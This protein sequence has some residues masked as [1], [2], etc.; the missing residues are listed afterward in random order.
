MDPNKHSFWVRVP[1]KPDCT[2]L[3]R[4][5]EGLVLP[6]HLQNFVLLL[7]GS[8]MKI[9]CTRTS[10]LENPTPNR[11]I[12]GKPILHSWWKQFNQ[13]KRIFVNCSA[14]E[15]EIT[16]R[17]ELCTHSLGLQDVV[18]AERRGECSQSYPFASQRPAHGHLHDTETA[19]WHKESVLFGRNW[20]FDPFGPFVFLAKNPEWLH[21][22]ILA[23]T[24]ARFV[25]KSDSLTLRWVSRHTEIPIEHGLSRDLD[26]TSQ[27]NSDK[28]ECLWT[29]EWLPT[30]SNHP[31]EL[32]S[33]VL[34][35]HFTIPR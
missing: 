5:L 28:M 26:L 18:L 20:S 24:L 14:W 1:A 4:R 29:I 2:L 33:E 31:N 6:K 34:H 11:N 27:I 25:L 7:L 16:R 32:L 9:S 10:Q 12:P 21:C 23:W 19:L 13:S 17:M 3:L 22:C 30:S 35:Q 8:W 15:N